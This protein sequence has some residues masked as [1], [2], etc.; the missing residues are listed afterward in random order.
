MESVVRHA[1]YVLAWSSELGRT[2]LARRVLDEPIVAF[3]KED[4]SPVALLDRCAHRL[5]PLSMGKV[6]GDTLQCGYHGLRYDATG[7]CVHVPGQSRIPATACVRH[8]PLVERYGATW[9]WMGQP[10]LADSDR[11]IPV[12]RFEED[13]WAVVWGEYQRHGSHYLNI[14]E[15]LQDPA[16]TTFVHPRTIG[17]P[18]SSDVPI[19]IEEEDDFIVA[20]RWTVD[21]E[22]P[23]ADR[24]NGHFAGLTDRCQRYIFYPPCV[25]RVD[26][27]TM[28]AGQQHT[29]SNMDR[30]LRAYSYKFLTPES[31]QSTHFFWM[32][33]RNFGVG[34]AALE[35]RLVAAM[36]TT[37]EED[38]VVVSAIQR[39][40]DAT[41][42]RQHT[43]LAIDTGPT[44]A[45]R[46]IE[47]LAEAELGANAEAKAG[48]A[49]RVPA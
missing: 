26:V 35:A 32:H 9:I 4:G 24:A 1:W 21:A 39:E 45:R 38:N 10:D 49:R 23:P 7:A 18:A 28:D 42:K 30:G 44:R 22:P 5:L 27:V 6:V 16:H 13:G 40:Q 48:L 8:F 25:S 12:Q 43:W 3:R 11:I 17:N 29:E 46:K 31:D 2:P 19:L 20:Y 14:V 47:Q 15:N 36:S 33:V 37:F 34:D 41:G